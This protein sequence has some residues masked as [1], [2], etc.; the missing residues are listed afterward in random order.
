MNNN[1]LERNIA[2]CPN[3]HPL[4]LKVRMIESEWVRVWEWLFPLQA[5]VTNTPSLCQQ[6]ASPSC[7]PETWPERLWSASSHARTGRRGLG[8]LRLRGNIWSDRGTAATRRPF[9]PATMRDRICIRSDIISM[10]V[11]ESTKSPH[12]S[13][14]DGR[15][16]LSL[17]AGLLSKPDLCQQNQPATTTGRGRERQLPAVSYQQTRQA[18][19]FQELR[20]PEWH[21]QCDQWG[22]GELQAQDYQTKK[23]RHLDLVF[24][25]LTTY[26]QSARPISSLVCWTEIDKS[27]SPAP[28]QSSRDCIIF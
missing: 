19:E 7:P 21:H 4:P 12:F 14:V 15:P 20:K 25:L 9:R 24:C 18:D 11:R 2:G 26:G 17:P 1:C 28:A 6:P 27:L 16:W 5:T 13:E 10:K 8:R 22:G 3:H 23:V